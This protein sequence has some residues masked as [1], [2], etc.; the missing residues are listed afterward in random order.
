MNAAGNHIHGKETSGEKMFRDLHHYYLEKEKLY[1][2]RWSSSVNARIV[3]TMITCF[4]VGFT[5]IPW[6]LSL[7]FPSMNNGYPFPLFWVVMVC[8]VQITHF[9]FF[10]RDYKKNYLLSRHYSA[11]RMA[12]S[13]LKA[14]KKKTTK[15]DIEQIKSMLSMKKKEALE[16][17]L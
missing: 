17:V 2:N 12:I 16:T 1:L 11:A 5:L 14:D 9:G 8:I 6:T 4:I 3:K 7:L 15:D 10:G 13:A